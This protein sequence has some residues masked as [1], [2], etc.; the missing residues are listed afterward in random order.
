M[1]LRLQNNGIV[2][3]GG[4]VCPCEWLLEPKTNFIAKFDVTDYS[5]VDLMI[6]FVSYAHSLTLLRLRLIS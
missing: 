4:S 3:K 2:V 5:R 6:G 1:T